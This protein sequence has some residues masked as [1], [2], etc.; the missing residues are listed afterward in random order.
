MEEQ[1]EHF[2]LAERRASELH[3]KMDILSIELAGLEAEMNKR[4][5]FEAESMA[6]AGELLQKLKQANEERRVVEISTQ[7]PHRTAFPAMELSILITLESIILAGDT[8]AEETVVHEL[9]T[10][11]ATAFAKRQFVSRQLQDFQK[12]CEE[13]EHEFTS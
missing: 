11:V 12:L 5:S 3:Q 8:Q 4:Q 7:V 2:F 9:Q 6:A 1:L 13:H 10:S